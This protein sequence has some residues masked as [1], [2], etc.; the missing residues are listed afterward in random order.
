MRVENQ[1]E[2]ALLDHGGI[3]RRLP[4]LQQLRIDLVLH[5]V[6]L[7]VAGHHAWKLPARVVD[8]IGIRVILNEGAKTRERLLLPLLA[9]TGA[10]EILGKAIVPVL[11][12]N[13]PWRQRLVCQ[14]DQVHHAAVDAQ[15][16]FTWGGL[17]EDLRIEAW[18]GAAERIAAGHA[19]GHRLVAGNLMQQIQAFKDCRPGKLET[20]FA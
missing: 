17:R 18:A 11:V 4:V 12:L 7:P 10:G 8:G 14:R 3:Q 16:L 9:A 19:K 15:V 6:R 1:G 13:D 20:L 5:V 2:R